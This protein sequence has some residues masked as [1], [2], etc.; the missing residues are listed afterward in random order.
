MALRA[1]NVEV[2]TGPQGG[3][4]S[5]TM[6]KETLA[7]SGLYLFA[8]PTHELI[9]EQVRDF[10]RADPSFETH[11]IYSQPGKGSTA[12]RLTQMREEMEARG[13][14]HGAIFTTHATLMDHSLDGFEKWEARVDEA[15]AAVQAGQFN[16]GVSTRKWLRDTYDL[17]S[18]PGDPWSIVRQKGD[19]PDWPAVKR[20]VGA[21]Q[22]GEFIKQA[23]Q[24]NRTF[25]RAKSWD[26]TAD[27]DWF[28]MWTPLSLAHFQSVQ[29]A[30]SGYTDS[31]G[32]R[33]ARDLYSGLLG[34]TIRKI[35]PRRTGQPSIRIHFF[36]RGHKGTTTYWESHEGLRAIA[37]ICDHL[38][39]KLTKTAF[40]SGNKVIET[41]FYGRLVAPN[42]IQPMAMG[43]NKCREMT[44][45]GF[46]FSATATADD[47]PLMAV[48]DLTKDDI[49][50]AREAEAI[51]QFV[52]R[53]AIRNL[54]YCGPYDIYLYSEVQ[55]E[56]LRDHLVNIGFAQVD[57]VAVD[58]AGIME[59]ER[60][61]G[62]RRE[63]TPEELADKV[64]ARRKADRV[65][66]QTKSHARAKAEG[67]EPSANNG[68]G[69]R[70]PGSKDKVP[71]KARAKSV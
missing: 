25:V 26:E 66:K 69:G 11:A 16:I 8:L 70:P 43:L 12:K 65:R 64:A 17:I 36:T 47:K 13:V 32:F 45:C 58:E 51:A 67:R 40:W 55:A 21:K 68:R 6:R 46:I 24:P 14:R 5:E 29:V 7:T 34:V 28:S 23:A 71:R 10:M 50:R 20:D 38:E 53:G 31:I 2:L 48:F 39:A 63:P 41:V 9:D 57:L 22:L 54:D 33:T 1:V 37:P 61:V 52:M 49:E 56:R 15:P 19:P 30:G 35:A 44:A 60:V 4:K 18:R 3:G 59:L 62:S 42:F 27:I